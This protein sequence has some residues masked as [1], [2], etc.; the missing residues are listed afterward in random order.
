MG[1]TKADLRAAIL[2][3]RRAV[4]AHEHNA[5]AAALAEHATTL[6]AAGQTVCAYVPVGAEPGSLELI[7]S[8]QRRGVR[9]LLPVARLDSTGS[10]LRLQWGEYVPGGLRVARFGLREPAEP[11]LTAEAVADATTL[12]VPALAVD[13][14][15]VRLGR[16]AGFYD[17]SLP[18]ASPSARLVA[19]V[20]DDE[21]VDRLPAE[22]HDVS[23]THALTP[24][25]GLV[26]LGRPAG[27]GMSIAT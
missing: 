16:G 8:L 26:A 5:E 27:P 21:L 13:R 3:A 20:R 9:V 7:D 19:V 22:P 2:S 17:R 14:Q 24:R 6:A 4:S 1:A 23:M 18:L 11:W 12:L 25:L 10:P 15:G